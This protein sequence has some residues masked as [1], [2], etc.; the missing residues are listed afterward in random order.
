MPATQVK[1]AKWYAALVDR[2]DGALRNLV[3]DGMGRSQ[4]CAIPF[5]FEDTFT[6]PTTSLDDADDI[7]KL[8]QFPAGSYIWG[9]RATPS[10]MDT[11]ATPTLTYSLLAIDSANTTK[12]TLVSAST[13]GQAA[14]GSD[15][16]IAGAQG[17]YVGGY[18]LALKVGDAAATPAAG[19]I[20]IAMV[21]FIGALNYTKNYPVLTD[22]SV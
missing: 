13:N 16:I 22:L 17:K 9:L 6:I 2:I 14:A 4:G 18:D 8:W 11:N 7:N 20:A 19:T 3:E 12:V 21:L 5:L 15:T 1:N 10:D